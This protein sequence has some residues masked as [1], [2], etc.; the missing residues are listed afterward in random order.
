MGGDGG[1]IPSR[2]DLVKTSGYMFSRNLG[3][4]GYLPNTQC[5]TVDEHLSSNQLKQLRWTTCALSQEP[6]S[7]P[8][9]SCKL[10]LLYNK[11]AVLRYI[12]SKKPR[13]SFEHLK[14]LKD[15]KDVKFMVDKDTNRFI[16]PILR[17]E[18]SATSRGVLIWKCGC[19]VSEKAFKKFINT[20]SNEGICPN[21]NCNFTFNPQVFN[22]SQNLPFNSDLVFLVPDLAEE[23]VLR[24]KLLQ[25]N[26]KNGKT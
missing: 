2:I 6:L 8:I 1:S 25:L 21:C 26:Q 3:G 19:C 24:T 14:G 15:I 10:G 12:L 4:M 18:L 17:T 11:E 5:R 16:C 23:G 7:S 13:A 20:S 22:K 9:V